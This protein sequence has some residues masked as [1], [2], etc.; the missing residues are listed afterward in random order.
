MTLTDK[1]MEWLNQN[2]YRSYPFSREEWR[3]KV[4]P[5]S[6]L[7]CVVLDALVFDADAEGDEELVIMSVSVSSDRTVVG[8]SYGRT[9]FHVSLSGGEL[10]GDG[11]FESFV[12]TVDRGRGRP[13]SVSISMSSHAYILDAVGEGSWDLG[14]GVIRSRVVRITD[15]YGVGGIKTNGSHCVEGHGE[16]SVASG[17]V[18]LEDGFRTSPI[19][20]RG[21]VLVRVGKKYGYDPCRHECGESYADDCRD[22]LLFFCGQNAINSGNVVIK[23]GRGVSVEQGRNY[24]VRSGSQAGKS[25]PCIE[26][27]AGS[28]LLDIYKPKV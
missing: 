1:T 9:A 21:K 18:V 28:E 10:S 8:M 12:G 23:G 15:G 17:D 13:A 19:I 24:V 27:I 22:Q 16:R 14:C 5:S 4:S 7:D 26:I 20:H 6:G 11:S 3:E 2:R 25:V